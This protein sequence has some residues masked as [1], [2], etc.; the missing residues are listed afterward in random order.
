MK[1]ENESSASRRFFLKGGALIAAAAASGS[2]AIAA[3]PEN[4]APNVPDWSK[5]LGD[6]VAVRAYGKPSKYEAHVVRRDVEWLTASRES[7]VSFTPLHE[8]EGPITPNSLCFE[9]H[10]GGI[11][12]IDPADHQLMIHGLVDK[13]LIYTLADLKRMPRV[14]RVYFAECAANSGMEWRGAQLNGCQYTHGMIHS[15]MYTGVPLKVLLEQAG[16]KNNAKW[17][18]L[19]GADASGMTRSL[20]LAKALDDVLIAYKMNGEALRPENGYPMRA[21]IPGWEA[22]MWVKWIRRIKVGDEPWHHREETSK[23]TD[24]LENGTARRFTY[25]MDAKS[26]ITNPSPQA[27]LT[28]RKGFTVLSG[29]AWS[30]RGKVARVDI[31]LDGGRNWRAARLDG[32]VWNK[33][34]TRF[35]YEFDWDGSELLLQSRAQDDTGYVQPTKVALRKVRGVNSIYHNNGIQTWQVRPNGEVENV[36][37]G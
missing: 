24:L 10:H 15:L 13:P 27:P 1:R 32:P 25:I 6:G 8:I 12:E 20:P 7:S 29:I 2:S 19:E 9:R 17:L 3:K 23:Y 35:Y 14:N 26:V 28:H 5:T 11:A 22:N 37:V 36:E 4:Q 31:S 30:G 16:L 34:V 21:V 18:L 33:A